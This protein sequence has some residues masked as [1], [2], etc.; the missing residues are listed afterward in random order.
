MLV[1]DGAP[2]KISIRDHH[3]YPRGKIVL[4]RSRSLISL[5]LLSRKICRLLQIMYSDHD[6]TAS[7]ESEAAYWGRIRNLV[8]L[9]SLLSWMGFG[10]ALLSSEY[11]SAEL[12]VYQPTFW[13][14]FLWASFLRRK[15]QCLS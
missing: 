3:A 9:T 2:H 10:A 13:A 1:S 8:A 15:R 11:T 6:G 5:H 7:K 12:T 4:P 14:N